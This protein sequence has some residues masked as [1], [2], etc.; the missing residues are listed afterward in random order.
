MMPAR[1][2][3]YFVHFGHLVRWHI[4]LNL[5]RKFYHSYRVPDRLC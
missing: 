5:P 2:I 3:V 1:F 4:S